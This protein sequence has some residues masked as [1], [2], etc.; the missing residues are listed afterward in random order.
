MSKLILTCVRLFPVAAIIVSLFALWQPALFVA[1]KPAIVPLLAAIMFGMGM[2]LTYADFVQVGRDGLVIGLGVLT[3][4][5][6]MPLAAWVIAMAFGLGPGETLGMV[7]VGA[8]AGGTAS[9][10]IAYLAGARVALSITMTL[11]STIVAIVFMPW[12]TWIY[13]GEVVDVDPWSMFRSIAMMVLLPVGLG[14]TLNTLFGQKVVKLRPV[15]PIVSV[16]SIVAIIGIVV[17]LNNERIFNL[18]PVILIAVMLHNIV[19]LA[20]G[21]GLPRLLRYDDQTCRTLS[22][23]V[24]MQNSGLAVALATSLFPTLPAA[25]LPGAIFSIWH[26]LSGSVLAA[27]WAGRGT[28]QRPESPASTSP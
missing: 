15:W 8:S 6:V 5:T 13:A 27:I 26:N 4:Y 20:A 3:Q 28:G 24:G 12:L 1:G 22:I 10:V 2:T 7:L 16:V 14:V 9:N 25:A 11:A 17:G 19:G 21:Y 18:G 23:E